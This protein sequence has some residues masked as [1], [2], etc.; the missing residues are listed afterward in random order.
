M[1]RSG[2]SRSGCGSASAE[3]GPGHDVRDAR[4]GDRCAALVVPTGLYRAGSRRGDRLAGGVARG[5]P[6]RCDCTS[7]H[8]TRRSP[9]CIRAELLLG[10]VLEKRRVRAERSGSERPSACLGKAGASRDGRLRPRRALLGHDR[11]LRAKR[12]AGSRRSRG[13]RLRLRSAVEH[14]SRDRS[15][16][17]ADPRRGYAR[18]RHGRRPSN[19]SEGT[20]TTPRSKTGPRA[21]AAAC[22]SRR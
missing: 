13:D 1:R 3:P 8:S 22:S 16:L 11:G 6:P 2:S 14:V 18:R 4:R 10:S 7:S 5:W 17:R 20:S 9:G 19:G 12:R 21:T 15:R